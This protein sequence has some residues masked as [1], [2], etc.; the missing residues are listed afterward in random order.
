VIC[1]VAA[2]RLTA[3]CERV[4][5]SAPDKAYSENSENLGSGGLFYSNAAFGSCRKACLLAVVRDEIR[6]HTT[7]H[8]SD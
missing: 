4:R 3:A 2:Y 5:L 8:F 6:V 7:R 1:F